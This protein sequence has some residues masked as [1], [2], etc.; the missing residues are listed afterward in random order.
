MQLCVAGSTNW[1]NEKIIHRWRNIKCRLSSG[2]EPTVTF[3][4]FQNNKEIKQSANYKIRS[5]RSG[6]VLNIRGLAETAGKISFSQQMQ[7]N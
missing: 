3:S 5:G 6:S 2:K 7:L 1:I 4:W